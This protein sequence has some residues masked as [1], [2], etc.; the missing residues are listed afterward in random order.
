MT[1]TTRPIVSGYPSTMGDDVQLNTTTF[2]RHAARTHGERE[3]VYRTSDG[4]WDRY[5]YA[6]AYARI[7]RSANALRGLGVQPGDRVGIVDWNSRRHFELY[8]AIPGIAACMVQLNLRL[9]PPDLIYVLQ[10]SGTSVVL[11]DET[12]L[13]L[14][15]AVAPHLPGVKAWVVMTD[16]PLSE[17]T[18]SIENLH[19]FEDLLSAADQTIDWPEVDEKSA[20]SACYTTGTTGRPKGV[21]YSHRAIC[22]HSYA[23]ATSIGMTLDDCTM[24][25]T[26]M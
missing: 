18:T 8:W 25:I 10:D 6:D 14:A 11:V 9:S 21:Y 2:I 4:G 19:H 1:A 13:P 26:P 16:K 5:T 15:E 24:I 22:L 20:Y 12:L 7:Q 23:L 3:I 17:I